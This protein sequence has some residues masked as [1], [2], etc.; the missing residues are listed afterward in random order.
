MVMKSFGWRTA[1]GVV[2]VV[3]WLVVAVA[4]ADAQCVMCRTALDSPEGRMMIAALRAGIL[5]LLA[6]PFAAFG[7]VAYFAVRSQRQLAS[8]QEESEA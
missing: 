4:P 2:L 1:L 8:Q 5:V 3:A 7:C 6:A